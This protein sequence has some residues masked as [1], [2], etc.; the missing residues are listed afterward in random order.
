MKGLVYL[1]IAVN[2]GVVAWLLGEWLRSR[3]KGRFW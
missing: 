3:T 2:V 1:V